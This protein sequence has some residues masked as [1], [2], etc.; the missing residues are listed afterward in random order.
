MSNLPL[1]WSLLPLLAI[2]FG[3]KRPDLRR[4]MIWAG[5]LVLP[6]LAIQPLISNGFWALLTPQQTLLFLVTR[7]L[8][9]FSLAAIAAA[10]YE[11]FWRRYFTPAPR[12]NRHHLLWLLVGPVIF[13]G[14]KLLGSSFVFSLVISLL[15]D[16]IIGLALRPDLL[17]DVLFSGLLMGLLY[18]L[19]F[20]LLEAAIPGDL[21]NLGW[22]SL[23][24]GLN[25]FGLPVE[26]LIIVILFGTLW[27]PLY[28][29]IKDL[30][31]V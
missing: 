27:G 2:A 10:V 24:S 20:W 23:P 29:A 3:W 18:G 30:R 4:Q 7:G 17:W 16:L 11:G 21:V 15:I 8:A 9:S 26:E 5:F 19:L 14:L 13:A 12:P 6:V 22:F 1:V 28:V 25:F 31:S